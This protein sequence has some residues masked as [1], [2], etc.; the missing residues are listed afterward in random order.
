P[1]APAQLPPLGG[2]QTHQYLPF[3]QLSHAE[4]LSPAI[5]GVNHY[6]SAYALKPP[7][8]SGSSFS[9]AFEARTLQTDPLPASQTD[10]LSVFELIRYRC[11][12]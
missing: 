4:R 3:V 11:S 10:S 2:K 12:P 1:A 5:E 8:P 6:L 9:A 7:P